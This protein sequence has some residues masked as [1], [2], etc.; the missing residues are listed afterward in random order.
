MGQDNHP[1]FFSLLIHLIY[2]QSKSPQVLVNTALSSDWAVQAVESYGIFSIVTM[3]GRTVWVSY[4]PLHLSH[5]SLADC[6]T[7]GN[8]GLL[9]GAGVGWDSQGSTEPAIMMAR[10]NAVNEGPAFGY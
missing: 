8:Y 1:K 7:L 2:D 5:M 9:N 10:S 4:S 3:V 6:R